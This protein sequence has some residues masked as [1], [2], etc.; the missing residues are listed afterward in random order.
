MSRWIEIGLAMAGVWMTACSGQ[1]PPKDTPS[2]TPVAER[3]ADDGHATPMPQSQPAAVPTESRPL[4]VLV[5]GFNDWKELGDP[6]NVWRCRDNPS[7]RLLLGDE[8]TTEPTAFEGPLVQR[9]RDSTSSAERPVQWTFATLPV[10][11]E[12]AKAAPRYENHDV[13]VHVG[14]GV[15]D[16]LDTV[17]VED[18]AFNRRHG[19]DAAGRALDEPIVA[20]VGQVLAPPHATITERVR[21]LDGERFADYRVEV[22]AAREAN[23]YLCN[24]T[25]FWALRAVQDA[26]AS[27]GRLRAAYFVHIPYA[28]DGDYESLAAGIAGIVKALAL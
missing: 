4:R 19:T 11:W 7:C 28:A 16:R 27:G 24:E 8:A 5:T 12:V 20:E 9:L 3:S 23:S 17:F 25:H 14:L 13:V 18:G 10:T 15:Y 2:A 6:P 1:R 26:N 22:K 21:A